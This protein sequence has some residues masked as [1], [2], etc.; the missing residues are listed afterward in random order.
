MEHYS[1]SYKCLRYTDIVDDILERHAG[2]PTGMFLNK[3]SCP[4]ILQYFYTGLKTPAQNIE[5]LLSRCSS[6]TSGQPGFLLYS[7]TQDEALPYNLRTLETLLANKT[8]MPPYGTPEYYTIHSHNPWDINR[9][10]KYTINRP[11]HKA[12]ERMMKYVNIGFDIQRKKYLKNIYTYDDALVKFTCLGNFSLFEVASNAILSTAQELSGEV[13][14]LAIMKNIYFGDWIKRYCLQHT[15]DIII[16][17]HVERYCGG[18]ISILWPTSSDDELFDKNMDGLYLV[19]SITHF[20][21]P[22]QKPVYTQRMVLIKNGYDDSDGSLTAAA[23]P[24]TKASV[25]EKGTWDNNNIR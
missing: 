4:E 2:M 19:K 5:W 13:E 3:E 15:V 7:S 1:R 18:M 11:D 21:S 12:L 17:G 20:F 22:L 23:K 24:N 9:I 8:L 25:P 6:E 16:E 10:L 14:E